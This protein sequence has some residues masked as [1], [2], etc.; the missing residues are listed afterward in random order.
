MSKK[1]GEGVVLTDKCLNYNLT[2]FNSQTPCKYLL[3]TH[4]QLNHYENWR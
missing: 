2:T 1:L 4:K 3:L